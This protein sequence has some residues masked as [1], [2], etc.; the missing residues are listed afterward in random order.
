MQFAKDELLLISTQQALMVGR[1]GEPDQT[2]LDLTNP[3]QTRADCSKLDQTRPDK[4]KPDQTR[5]DQ[6][7]LDL[8][9]L[10]QIRQE[11]TKKVTPEQTRLDQIRHL[12]NIRSLGEDSAPLP[13][14]KFSQAQNGG[15][16]RR[17]TFRTLFSI[18]LT[19]SI[20]IGEKA[21]NTF[22]EDGFLGTLYFAIL[23]EKTA[24]VFQKVL[25]R[26]KT[27][28]KSAK[29]CNCKIERFA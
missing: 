13:Q 3:G 16:Y 27:Q 17:E 28:S 18:D 20:K 23:G 6:T 2:S 4:T 12:F 14:I 11:Q 25:F 19:S 26:S 8:I 21:S 15:R 10:D 24:Q 22:R 5:L 9:T 29:R 1:T 7:R